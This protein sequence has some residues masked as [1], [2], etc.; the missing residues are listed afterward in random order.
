MVLL[1]SALPKR[2]QLPGLDFQHGHSRQ[3]GSSSQDRIV[4]SV[5]QASIDEAAIRTAGLSSG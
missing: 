4:R 3:T 1:T 5:T 2:E